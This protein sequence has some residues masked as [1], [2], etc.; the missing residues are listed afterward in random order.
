MTK[1]YALSAAGVQNQSMYY[2]KNDKK[3][4]FLSLL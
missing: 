4:Q 1:T 3:S 2:L